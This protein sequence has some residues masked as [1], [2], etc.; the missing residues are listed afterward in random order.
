[1]DTPQDVAASDP[2]IDASEAHI[3]SSP[4]GFSIEDWRDYVNRTRARESLLRVVKHEIST[5]TTFIAACAGLVNYALEHP[6]YEAIAR[7]QLQAYMPPEPA[8]PAYGLVALAGV[9]DDPRFITQLMD[10]AVRIRLARAACLNV[11]PD[12]GLTELALLLRELC[13]DSI[14][15]LSLVSA[16]LDDLNTPIASAPEE[17]DVSS[18]RVA[19]VAGHGGWP[20]IDE[21]GRVEIA[22]WVENRRK[23]RRRTL[24]GCRLRANGAIAHV[25][26][27]D[28]SQLG[29]G[30]GN[31]PPVAGKQ[32]IELFL[33]NGHV[34]QAEVMWQSGPRCGVKFQEPLS[35]AQVQAIHATA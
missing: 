6:A 31:A 21:H 2:L 29:A 4:H 17:A 10:F 11:A 22:Q 33:Q 32:V 9:E 20:C 24:I 26:I 8:A 13:L 3:P 12:G 18:E 27:T 34:L 14:A 23:S 19:F 15:A 5:C 30:L 7:Q 16:S 25:Y 1:M 35:P 28:L